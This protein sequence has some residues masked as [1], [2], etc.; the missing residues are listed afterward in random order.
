[1]NILFLAFLHKN[2]TFRKRKKTEKIELSSLHFIIRINFLINAFLNIL[3]FTF[4]FS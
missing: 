4:T 1:M 2:V 3:K